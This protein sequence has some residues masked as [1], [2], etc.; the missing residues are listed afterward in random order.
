MIG[1][2]RQVKDLPV[3]AI[4]TII[5]MSDFDRTIR[6]AAGELARAGGGDMV[7]NEGKQTTH[8]F[9]ERFDAIKRTCSYEGDED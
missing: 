2:I 3:N 5:L 6:V 1:N 8:V 4:V 7:L 9:A